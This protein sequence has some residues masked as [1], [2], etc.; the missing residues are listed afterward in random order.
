[1]ASFLY[2]LPGVEPQQLVRNGRIENAELR[3]WGLSGVLAY[4]FDSPEHIA[5]TKLDSGGPG[6]ASGLV[7]AVHPGDRAGKI[8]L[9][10]SFHAESQDWARIGK[11]EAVPWIGW[12]R[13]NPPVP[14]DLVRRDLVAGY[15]WV[16]HFGR[17]WLMPV[18]RGRI[19]QYGQLPVDYEWSPDAPEPGQILRSEFVQLWNDSAK[20]WDHLYT[21]G[22][23]CPEPFVAGFVAR[24]FAINYRVGGRELDVLRRM[25]RPVFDRRT[26]ETWAGLACDV[27]AVLEYAR[28]K[29]MTVSRAAVAGICS[30]AGDPA[31]TQPFSP[32]AG[33]S[34]S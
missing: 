15:R 33:N 32:V 4:C 7:L 22:F 17:S 21:E 24:C 5:L 6:K 18:V 14:E 29:K 28:Q 9:V 31:G 1:M 16:D 3:R 2:F 13:E 11:G 26:S 30:S 10:P 12:E 23:S 20:I 27:P 19:N 34:E 25:G 8:P